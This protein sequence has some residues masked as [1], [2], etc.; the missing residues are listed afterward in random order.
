MG[1]PNTAA[2]FLRFQGLHDTS[3]LAKQQSTFPF[4]PPHESSKSE[5]PS[6]QIPTKRPNIPHQLLQTPTGDIGLIIIERFL[7]YRWIRGV[8][9]ILTQAKTPVEFRGRGNTV[10]H[11]AFRLIRRMI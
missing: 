4:V 3:G 1:F 7:R 9:G 5:A 6:P 8:Q 11:T 2:R 10:K